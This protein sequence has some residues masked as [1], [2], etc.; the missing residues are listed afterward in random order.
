MVELNDVR[1]AKAMAHGE[2]GQRR[3]AQTCNLQ[4]TLF[5]LS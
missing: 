4:E 5:I 3:A 1:V 2:K